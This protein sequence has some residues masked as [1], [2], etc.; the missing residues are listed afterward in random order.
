M[1][2]FNSY[3]KL[4]EGTVDGRNLAPADRWFIPWFMGF[5][6][7]KVKDFAGPSTVAMECDENGTF[8]DDLPMKHGD[9]P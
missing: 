4:P 8:T 6:P 2:I 5:Q 7:S 1:V 9:S 3:V